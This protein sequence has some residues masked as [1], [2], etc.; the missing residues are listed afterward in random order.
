MKVT[1]HARK[2]AKE[3][4]GIGKKNIVQMSS[5]VFKEGLT[6]RDLNGKLKGWVSGKYICNPAANNI[7]LYGDQCYIFSGRT[8]ITVF[9]IPEEYRDEARRLWKEKTTPKYCIDKNDRKEVEDFVVYRIHAL[10][11]FSDVKAGDLGGYIMRE[12]NLSQEGTCW[13]YDD[14]S[15][16]GMAVVKDKAKIKEQAVI[17]KNA[18]VEDSAIVA[19]TS[20]VRGSARVCENVVIDGCHD[21]RGTAVIKGTGILP[22]GR[23]VKSGVY[24]V[25]ETEESETD[26]QEQTKSI[27]CPFAAEADSEKFCMKTQDVC[28]TNNKDNCRTAKEAEILEVW[29]K[30]H[31]YQDRLA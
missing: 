13:V 19:G 20:I 12:Q 5:R 15:V 3:R 9:P 30:L 11:D 23:N 29:I 14:A 22:A 31:T 1:R 6:Y 27:F 17:C 28:Q 25:D 8:L 24:V 26:M 7:R 18:V 10:K 21:I 4:A 2:R 16:Y